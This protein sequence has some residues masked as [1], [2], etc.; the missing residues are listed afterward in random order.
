MAP[1]RLA[2]VVVM[3]AVQVAWAG[4]PARPRPPARDG[5][6]AE[7][8][9]AL[10]A[11]PGELRRYFELADYYASRQ[12]VSEADRVLRDALASVDPLA[13]AVYER[14]VRLFL[15]PFDPLRIGAVAQ[16]WLSVDGTNAVPVLLAAGHQLRSA[17]ERRGDGTDGAMRHLEQGIAAVDGAFAANPNMPALILAKAYLVWARSTLLDDPK[18]QRALVEEAQSLYRSAEE[19]PASRS[20][21][22]VGEGVAPVVA[23]MLQ[24]PPFGPPGA[25][26]AP[27]LVPVPRRLKGEVPVLRRMPPDKPV[28]FVDL[29]I[30]VDPSG[31]VMQVHAVRSV[32]GFDQA[33]ADAI[34]QWEFE[35]TFLGGKAVPVIMRYSQRVR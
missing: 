16:E 5:R 11:E 12:R 27:R 21:E 23:A 31:H 20:E 34:Q 6:E 35:P 2:A 10:A 17:S 1:W 30:V 18:K 14:R 29:E 7:L 25:V 33:L 19:L 24:M 8:K 22:P 15:D 3:L 26:R 13:R 9:A 4:Q 32:E 28:R